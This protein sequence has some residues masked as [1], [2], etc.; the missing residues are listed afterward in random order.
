MRI[1]GREPTVVIQSLAALL[2]IAV[3]FKVPG[4][5]AEQAGLIIAAIY[6]VLGAVN[7]Y[8]VRPVTPAAFISAVGAVTA[9]TAAYGL[10]FTQEQ[11]GSISSAIVAMIVLLTRSQVSPVNYP[12]VPR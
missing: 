3:A 8:T 12:P 10:S 6:A 4:L 9:L 7:A 5:S 1:F 2:S 11:V